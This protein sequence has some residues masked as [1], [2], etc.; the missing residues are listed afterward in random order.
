MI[1]RGTTPNQIFNVDLDLTGTEVLYLTYKQDKDIVLEKT[2]DDLTITKDQVSF[3]M[4][5]EES[6]LFNTNITV[7][8]QIRARFPDGTAVESE[9]VITH[10]DGTAVKSNIVTTDTDYL[11]K[12]GVI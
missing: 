1:P 8:M 10:P 5:Q 4:T 9:G 11:L 2:K 7:K 12:E 3:R 6:L